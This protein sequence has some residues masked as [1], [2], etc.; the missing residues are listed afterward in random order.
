MKRAELEEKLQ[1]VENAKEIIDF[2]MSE[3]GKD[4]EAHKAATEKAEAERLE[5]E[6]LEN[7]RLAQE[8]AERVSKAAEEERSSAEHV[9][10]GQLP[11]QQRDGEFLCRVKVRAVVSEEI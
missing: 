4:I 8:E 6:R 11:G 7:E 5:N 1:G 9:K 3:N 2:V 10:K